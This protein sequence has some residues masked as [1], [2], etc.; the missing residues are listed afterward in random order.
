M[1]TFG[2]ML[3][4]SAINAVLKPMVREAM[5]LGPDKRS[6]IKQVVHKTIAKTIN[7]SILGYPFVRD[8]HIVSIKND[9]ETSKSSIYEEPED[10]PYYMKIVFPDEDWSEHG[11]TTEF[12]LEGIL[13][14]DV[15]DWTRKQESEIKRKLRLVKGFK[16]KIRLYPLD[17]KQRKRMFLSIKQI[18]GE[19]Q[20]IKEWVDEVERNGPDIFGR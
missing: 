8:N 2:E 1:D 7:N 9:I 16:R 3:L 5:G 12:K 18:N 15:E 11:S 17:E 10:Y 19:I 6:F 20:E 4:R 14:K 13:S